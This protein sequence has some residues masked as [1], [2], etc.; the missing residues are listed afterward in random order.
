MELNQKNTGMLLVGFSIVLIVVL[1][2]VKID[3]DRRGAFLCE[4]VSENPD[5][6]M[7]ECPVH[8]NN[9]SWLIVGA[10]ALSFII[11]VIGL[12]LI[13]NKNVKESQEFKKIDISKLDNEEKK[14]Y[15]MVKENEGAMYQSDIIKEIGLSKVNVTRLLDRMEN[16]KV[17]ERKRRGMTNLIVLK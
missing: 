12:Y 7:K 13:F 11:L 6:D 8:K 16:K 10:F 4:M 5:M 15:D 3:M 9:T 1:I 14:I 2:F 17:L